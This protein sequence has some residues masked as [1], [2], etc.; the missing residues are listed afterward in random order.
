MRARTEFCL[1]LYAQNITQ[2]IVN[3]QHVNIR[4]CQVLL[5]III[6]R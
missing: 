6:A 1:L 4:Y 5:D 2:Y 3:I